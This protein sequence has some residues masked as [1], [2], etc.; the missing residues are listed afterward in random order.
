[1]GKVFLQQIVDA[2]RNVVGQSSPNELRV[3]LKLMGAETKRQEV[4]RFLKEE[5]QVQKVHRSKRVCIWITD[6][7]QPSPCY[8]GRN[9]EKNLAFLSEIHPQKSGFRSNYWVSDN[10][11]TII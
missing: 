1:M 5:Q 2:F 8:R 7:L 9:Y 6:P 11:Q 10:G 4:M 3:S